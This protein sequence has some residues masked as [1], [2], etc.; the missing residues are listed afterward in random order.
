MFKYYFFAPNAALSDDM[1]MAD[2]LANGDV[3]RGFVVYDHHTRHAS[4]G[5]KLHEDSDL[6]P[7]V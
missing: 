7:S 6:N 5:V 3:E 1:T 4:L 2:F